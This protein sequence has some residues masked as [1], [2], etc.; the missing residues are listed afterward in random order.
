MVWVKDYERPVDYTGACAC[1]GCRGKFP[2]VDDI[3]GVCERGVFGQR[4]E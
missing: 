2:V 1:R 4:V 3:S